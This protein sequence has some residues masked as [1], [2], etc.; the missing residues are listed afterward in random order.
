MQQ[1]IKRYWPLFLIIPTLLAVGA[2][3]DLPLSQLLYQ[4]QSMLGLVME[5]FGFFP[6]Y[7]PLIFLC[8]SYGKNPRCKAPLR[9]LLPV[10][11]AAGWG[12]LWYVGLHHLMKRNALSP[13]Q[14]PML[15][16]LIL[17]GL[18][19][20]AMCILPILRA[21]TAT[22]KKLQFLFWVGSVYMMLNNLLI[23][24]CKLLWQR[25]RFDDM[26][27]AGSF[28][29]FTPWY[30]PLGNGGSSFP[31]GHTAAAC[32]VFVLLSACALF[33]RWRGRERLVCTLCWA[34]VALMGAGRILIGRHFLSD[35]VIA[36][37]LGFLLY[38]WM[39]KTPI[40]QKALQ[41]ALE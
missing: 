37:L 20:G 13:S 27:R 26:L 39:C 4:P 17:A 21:P 14:T 28:A 25:T 24:L 30:L 40:Y 36:A 1:T 12:A 8:I 29:D 23:N 3:W 38:L 7:L 18:L 32:A 16:A 10:I 19:L 9:V 34:Y 15:L 31:S 35:T 22:V 41:K 2:L 33:A 5:C 6:L 11:G